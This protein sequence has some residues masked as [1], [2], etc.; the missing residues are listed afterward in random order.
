MY[1]VACNRIANFGLRSEF[2]SARQILQCAMQTLLCEIQ[3]FLHNVNFPL[4][5]F[6]EQ[7]AIDTIP[8]K[9]HNKTNIFLGLGTKSEIF[10]VLLRQTIFTPNGLRYLKNAKDHVLKMHLKLTLAR[11]I[12]NDI[13]TLYNA[14]VRNEV[15]MREMK[16][17][18]N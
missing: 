12:L 14:K 5:K 6:K 4:L 11:D 2:S 1:F 17:E 15:K 16:G 7:N 8:Y 13:N 3:I 10:S 18:E 9:E